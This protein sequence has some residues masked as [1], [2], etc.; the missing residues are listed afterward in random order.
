MRGSLTLRLR[1]SSVALLAGVVCA[2]AFV[3]WLAVGPIRGPWIVPDEMIYAARGLDFWHHG[4]LPLFRGPG[5]GYGLFYP[6]LA[7]LPLSIGRTTEAYS[8]LKLIQP[9]VV[10]LAAVPV[11]VYARRLMPARWA[12]VAAVLTCASPLLIYS[13]FVMTEVLY[14][15]VAALTL[16][17]IARAV[18]TGTP[19]DQALAIVLVVVAA[20]TRA[21]GLAL[22]GV[23]PAAAGLDAV[24]S[25]DLRRLRLFWPSAAVLLVGLAA[26]FAFPG[27]L[28][29]YGETLRG[30]YPLGSA[31]G[32]AFDHLAYIAFAVAVLPFAA[33]IALGID[34]LRGH[35]DVSAARGL[36]AV[37]LAATVVCTVQVG[38]FAAR[39]S[40]HLLGRDL[41]ALPPVLFTVFALWLSRGAPRSLVAASAG[42]YALLALLLLTPWNTLVASAGIADSFDLVI[43]AKLPWSAL[44]TVMIFAIAAAVAFLFLPRRVAVVVLPLVTLAALVASSAVAARKLVDVTRTERLDVVGTQPDWID[45]AARGPVTEV[46]GGEGSWSTVW[47]ERFWN[48]RIDRVVTLGGTPVP[49]PMKQTMATLGVR[50]ELPTHDGYAVAPDRFVFSGTRVAHL[51][52][53][54]SDVTGLTLWRLAEPPRMSTITG[55]VQPNG[56]IT[57]PATVSVYDCRGGEL[58][59]T[60]IPKATSRLR[61]RL[62]GSDVVDEPISGESWTRVI[63]VPATAKPRL[64]TFTIYPQPLLGSTR[65]VFSRS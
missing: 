40:P 61:I 25:R 6:L 26:V 11:Y 29:A 23:L 38:F 64:C 49:G 18:A 56:D 41:A 33:L 47:Q 32:L 30:G 27:L 39:Y 1:R 4:P 31:L 59:L 60:L 21:Q 34:A 5:V 37:A 15:P 14:Y 52:Q 53:A 28:G 3:H 62:D 8:L 7:G 2:S 50:G 13:G 10:S 36:V 48:R 9:F 22:A 57:H 35:E 55:G 16:F 17:S 20:L 54:I 12:I 45:R 51:T 63:P 19:R 24:M 44:T 65:I 43:V 58:E 42:L 46:Y